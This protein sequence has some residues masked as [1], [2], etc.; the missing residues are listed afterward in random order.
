MQQGLCD[1]LP[2]SHAEEHSSR[3]L[4]GGGERLWK[5]RLLVLLLCCCCCQWLPCVAQL[6]PASKLQQAVAVS[7]VPCTELLLLLLLQ[8]AAGSRLWLQPPWILLCR[9]IQDVLRWLL[10]L[11]LLLRSLGRQAGPRRLLEAVGL[12]RTHDQMMM[13]VLVLVLLRWRRARQQRRARL[14][15]LLTLLLGQRG[16]ARLWLQHLCIRDESVWV[17]R[18]CCRYRCKADARATCP[19]GAAAAGSRVDGSRQPP[20]LLL[21]AAP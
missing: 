20:V 9:L 13:V 19:S 15:P 8:V 11:L 7:A 6:A 1:A 2:P 21:A 14:L 4:S 5:L 16:A 12:K 18:C 17:G 10:L 3:V